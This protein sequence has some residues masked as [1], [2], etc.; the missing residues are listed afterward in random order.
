MLNLQPYGFKVQHCLLRTAR[1]SIRVPRGRGVNTG[2][3]I[4]MV[5]LD[6]A[7]SKVQHLLFL[8]FLA[9][10]LSVVQTRWL[11]WHADSPFPFWRAMLVSL[12]FVVQGNSVSLRSLLPSCRTATVG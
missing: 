11:D 4:R 12:G 1:E 7:P 5:E 3:H 2:T 10:V 8:V 6:L 9:A